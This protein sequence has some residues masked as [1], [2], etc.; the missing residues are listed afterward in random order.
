MQD[1]IVRKRI[2]FD[3]TAMEPNA[4]G[5]KYHGAAEYAK[6]VFWYLTNN[7]YSIEMDCIYSQDSILDMCK[8]IASTNFA[9][10][11][12][13]IKTHEDINKVLASNNYETFYSALP[14][15]YANLVFPPSTKFVYTIHGLRVAEKSFDSHMLYYNAL[16]IRTIFNYIE[17][18]IFHKKYEKE[19]IKKIEKLFSVTKNR[20]V[21]TVSNHSKYSILHMCKG[22]SEEE[23]K[24]FHSPTGI[25]TL[26]SDNDTLDTQNIM[27]SLGINEN[28][29]FL[30]ISSNRWIKNTY[31][32]VK[33]FDLLYSQHSLLDGYKVVLLG[34]DEQCKFV[35]KIQNKDKFVLAGYVGDKALQELYEKAFAFVYPTLNEGYGYPPIESMK[36]NTVCMCS[37]VS[38]I[39]EICQN[40]ACYFNPY[41]INEIQNRI[42][43]ILNDNIRNDYISKGKVRYQEVHEIQTRDL[44]G[45]CEQILN[46]TR[47]KI[48]N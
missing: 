25:R 47:Q 1:K 19:Y 40:A 38:S 18:M 44:L 6:N 3:L 8:N 10:N 33:A 20:C 29:Y 34:I 5:S 16:N 17:R 46:T 13:K 48:V 35:N 9:I 45:I 28:R 27:E 42:Y 37:A 26:N 31:R 11:Y 15:N 22:I 24:V 36:Y 43:Q 41:D 39:I 30:L 2:L 7:F 23:I 32:A 4:T 14:Y 21:I 12:I